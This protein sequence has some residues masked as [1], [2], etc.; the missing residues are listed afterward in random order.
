MN[1]D[2]RKTEYYCE[3]AIEIDPTYPEPYFILINLMPS[4]MFVKI[5]MKFFED[6]AGKYPGRSYAEKAVKKLRQKI[7]M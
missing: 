3:K 5:R 2:L 1:R 7:Q 6:I 4:P